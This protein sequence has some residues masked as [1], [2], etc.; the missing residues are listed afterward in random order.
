MRTVEIEEAGTYHLNVESD[1][2]DFAV[3]IGKNPKGRRRSDAA[4]GGGSVAL[5]GL[6]LGLL[7]FLLGLRRR[8]PDPAPAIAARSAD[9][10]ARALRR[11][12]PAGPPGLPSHPGYRLDPPP[13]LTQPIQLPGQ[14]PIRLPEH[15]T[16]WHL[17]AADVRSTTVA[18]RARC[19]DRTVARRAD[20]RTAAARRTGAR[21]T[22]AR[23]ADAFRRCRRR[24]RAVGG[25][26]PTPMS[27]TTTSAA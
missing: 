19:A 21:H 13:P 27:P 20:V 12:R 14:P 15:A 6:V 2:S 3:A 5:G 4:I 16:W 10:A 18:C 26:S 9:V 17:R 11:R 8:R 25:H 24:H 1:E 23:A 22:R 7:F